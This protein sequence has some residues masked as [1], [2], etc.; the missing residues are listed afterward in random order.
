MIKLLRTAALAALVVSPALSA[1]SVVGPPRKSDPPRVKLT[2]PE[3]HFG[4]Q[5]GA[6]R[7]MAHWDDMVKYYDLLGKTSNRMKVVNMG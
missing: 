2:T 6:D 5:M 7:K 1:Q 4:F 3:A